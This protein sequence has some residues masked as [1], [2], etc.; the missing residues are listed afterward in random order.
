MKI[1]F[2]VKK[3]DICNGTV[4]KSDCSETFVTINRKWFMLNNEKVSGKR[5]LLC[6]SCGLKVMN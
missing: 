4:D 5:L 2:K 3:C 6:D 1:Y